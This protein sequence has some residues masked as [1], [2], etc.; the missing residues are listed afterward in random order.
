M[1]AIVDPDNGEMIDEATIKIA[2]KQ[3]LK[4]FKAGKVEE[5]FLKKAMRS[6]AHTGYN[7]LGAAML[8][9]V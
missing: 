1:G 6:A 4:G 7:F 2:F 8:E 5:D 9:T 3:L